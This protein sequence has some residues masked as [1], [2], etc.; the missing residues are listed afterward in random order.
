MELS[1]IAFGGGCHWCTEAVFQSVIGVEDVN[2]G[3]AK[4]TENNNTFSEAVILH[5]NQDKVELQT[6]IHI[7]LLTH[8]ST[9]NHSMRKK[10]RSA[11]YYYTE[12]QKE[13]ST[14][15]INDLQSD[16]QDRIITK[17]IP[18]QEFK[19]SSEAFQNYYLQNPKKPFCEKYINPKLAVL[20]DRFKNHY[21]QNSL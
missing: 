2:Q 13:R 9:R 11:I 3:W 10:Y 16:F 15:I 12:D 21:K 18:F 5:F 1:K 19:P 8:K 17:V 14:N 7:H 4:S 6:L 20:L